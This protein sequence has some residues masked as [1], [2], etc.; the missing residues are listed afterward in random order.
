MRPKKPASRSIRS[1]IRPGSESLSWTTPLLIPPY[2]AAA[3]SSMASSSFSAIGFS[4]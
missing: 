2:M 4:V 3:T 1:F